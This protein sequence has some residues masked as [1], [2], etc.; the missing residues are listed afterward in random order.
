M[1]T[2]LVNKIADLEARIVAPV[3]APVIVHPWE[4][5]RASKLANVP[6]V[7]L[8]PV[9]T[10]LDSIAE[11]MAGEK[12]NKTMRSAG[13]SSTVVQM[14]SDNPNAVMKLG[15]SQVY[16]CLCSGVSGRGATSGMQLTRSKFTLMLGGSFYP[17]GLAWAYFEDISLVLANDFLELRLDSVRTSIVADEPVPVHSAVGLQVNLTR[18]LMNLFSVIDLTYNLLDT[19]AE[20]LYHGL[21]T[22]PTEWFALH[23]FSSG[24]ESDSVITCVLSEIVKWLRRLHLSI[25]NHELPNLAAF[26]MAA[27][28]GPPLSSPYSGPTVLYTALLNKQVMERFVILKQPGKS[29]G[30]AKEKVPKKVPCGNSAVKSKTK[31]SSTVNHGRLLKTFQLG[32]YC[33]AEVFVDAR[34]PGR[35]PCTYVHDDPPIAGSVSA[36]NLKK[37]HAANPTVALKP[38]Y[39]F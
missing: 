28:T 13:L 31:T 15:T 32:K 27:H 25:G 19:A 10:T 18:T 1:Y 29:L 21:V 5:N 22:V 8:A 39:K 16:N 36:V 11:S 9:A 4:K 24:P 26:C 14:L 17:D 20:A 6:P 34:C 2:F 23:N 33:S 7:S 35:P 30:V 37:L 12:S 38:G 3:I